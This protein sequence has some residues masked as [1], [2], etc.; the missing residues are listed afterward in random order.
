[1]K[2]AHGDEVS[3]FNDKT[4][5]RT[6]KVDKQLMLSGTP[7]S[8]DNFKFGLF[9]QHEGFFSPRHRHNFCQFR[10]AIKGVCDYGAGG[11]MTP[12]TVG[13]FTEGAYYGPQGPDVGDSYTATVQFGGPSGQGYVTM[14]EKAVAKEALDK[15]GT[16]ENGVFRRNPGVPGKKN[17]DGFEALWEQA[18]GRDLVYPPAQYEFPV[19]MHPENFAWTPVDG[20]K[21]VEQKALG[22]FLDCQIPCAIYRLSSGATFT[23]KGRGIYLVLS[24]GGSVQGE[25]YRQF[26]AVYLETG[27]TAQFAAAAVTEVLLLGLPNLADIATYAPPEAAEAKV[28]EYS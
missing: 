18:A 12:G 1:M 13:F 16:F 11:K 25:N 23:A 5:V 7:G 8:P 17:M 4:S 20:V 19:L 26:T 15:I 28:A 3:P 10:V 24:G 21:G 22:T 6:G 2:I 27:E 9:G 14:A